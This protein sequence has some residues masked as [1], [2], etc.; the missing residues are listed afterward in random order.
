MNAHTNGFRYGGERAYRNGL[1]QEY[2]ENL[3]ELKAKLKSAETVGEQIDLEEQIDELKKNNKLQR[4]NA[5]RN[6]Y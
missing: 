2:R 1:L 4:K 6:L 3:R 5:P